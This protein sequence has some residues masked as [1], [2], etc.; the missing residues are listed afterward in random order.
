MRYPI[1][2]IVHNKGPLLS[3]KSEYGINP[4]TRDFPLVKKFAESVRWYK[5][6]VYESGDDTNNITNAN[7]KH[8]LHTL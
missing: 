8:R 3:V 6:W 1:P 4:F 2:Y 5:S 7:K